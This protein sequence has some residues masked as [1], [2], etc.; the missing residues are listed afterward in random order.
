MNITLAI[1]GMSE[2]KLSFLDPYNNTFGEQNWIVSFLTIMLLLINVC[3][4]FLL[5]GTFKDFNTIH[6]QITVALD[7]VVPN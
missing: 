7:T 6:A 5:I 3:V 4:I 1:F 2:L